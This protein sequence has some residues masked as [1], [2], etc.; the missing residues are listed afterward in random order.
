MARPRARQNAATLT[1]GALPAV[2]QDWHELLKKEEAAKEAAKAARV[3]RKA[4]TDR[5][6]KEVATA[7]PAAP[8][9]RSR[10]APSKRSLSGSGA[11]EASEQADERA[12]GLAGGLAGDVAVSPSAAHLRALAGV[13]KSSRGG[14]RALAAEAAETGS[15]GGSS[16]YSTGSDAEAG[17]EGGSHGASGAGG[18]GGAGG[19]KRKRVSWSDDGRRKPE[20]LL[21]V[22]PPPGQLQ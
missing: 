8:Q 6:R 17:A 20:R 16:A 11:D 10:A 3:A 5:V 22:V 7:A 19:N 15:V 13:E 1:L 4:P 14:K 21:N 18:A 9:K 2:S 12:G